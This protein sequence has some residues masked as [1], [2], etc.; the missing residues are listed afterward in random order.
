MKIGI[1]SFLTDQSVRTDVLARAVE[2]RGFESLLV[3][4]HSHVPVSRQTPYPGGGEL[5]A[6]YARIL[7]PFLVLATAAAV[8][9]RITLGTGICLL[10]QR[11]VIYAAK[12]VASLDYLS[13]GRVMLGV[14]PG[15]M[16]EQMRNHG[17]DPRTRGARLDEQ[18]AAMK[19]IW[20]DDEAEFHGKFVDFD[21]IQA[22]PKP[23]QRPHPP[24]Y[25]GGGSES[26]LRRVQEQGDGWLATAAAT[27]G[28]VRAQAAMAAQ[29]APGM[30]FSVFSADGN[31]L[32]VLDA[33][34]ESGAERVALL[35]E[36]A[37]EAETLTYLDRLA[38][39]NERYA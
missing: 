31:N 11:D 8:T 17:T 6:Y 10:T 13:G 24:I 38:A 36:P 32:A 1:G 16:R 23:V 34:Q 26:T 20:T 5:P 3:P 25:I 33:Y 14:A 39:L 22:W 2:E 15:W 4:E 27:P 9:S 18:L 7:H 19:Q 21:P 29:H 28:Q 12:E 37:P 35:L 30:P